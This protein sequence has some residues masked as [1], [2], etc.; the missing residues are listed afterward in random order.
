M[1]EIQLKTS[2]NR[3]MS[4][5]D[6]IGI[7][8]TRPVP[9][10][11]GE[12]IGVLTPTAYLFHSPKSRKTFLIH[13][14][15]WFVISRPNGYDDMQE[16]DTERLRFIAGLLFTNGLIDCDP[17]ETLNECSGISVIPEHEIEDYIINHKVQKN[18]IIHWA[19]KVESKTLSREMANE[20]IN[21]NTISL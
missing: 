3:I 9:M 19:E 10:S 18:H 8:S 16:K 21:V 6:R 13:F 12:R 11:N 5:L 20:R 4:I 2:A 1:I 17:S 7:K 15:E 14:K